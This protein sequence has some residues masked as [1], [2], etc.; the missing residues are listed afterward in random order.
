MKQRGEMGNEKERKRE[1]KRLERERR[2]ESGKSDTS[3]DRKERDE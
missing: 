2:L 3:R 1:D